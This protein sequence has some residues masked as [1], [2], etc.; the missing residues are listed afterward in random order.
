MISDFQDIH[1]ILT[2]NSKN[3]AVIYQFCGTITHIPTKLH[4]F[5]IDNLL[6]TACIRT[7]RRKGSE[8]I[9]CFAGCTIIVIFVYNFYKQWII[10]T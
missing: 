10:T 3:A 9:S 1:H 5:V 8:T 4:T 2:K 6:A 7:H